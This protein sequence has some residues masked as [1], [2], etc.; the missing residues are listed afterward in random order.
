MSQE[1][2]KKKIFELS[3]LALALLKILPHWQ[4][5]SAVCQHCTNPGSLEGNNIIIFLSQKDN[6]SILVR[7]NG[8]HMGEHFFPPNYYLNKVWEGIFGIQDL[9]KIRC[10]SWENYKYID[11]I[12]DLTLLLEAGL[13]KNWAQDVGFMFVCWSGMPETV[14]T[15]QF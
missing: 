5:A 9:T 13:A 1:Q 4:K 10:G 15:N 12:W 11:G 2:C 6:V 3:T 14:M 8:R 7:Q